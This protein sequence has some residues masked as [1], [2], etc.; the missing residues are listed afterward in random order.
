MPG[1]CCRQTLPKVKST[2]LSVPVVAKEIC[3][4]MARKPGL[5]A[6]NVTAVPLNIAALLTFL[7]S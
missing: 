1:R 2:A 4:K 6:S 7:A 5:L 3:D